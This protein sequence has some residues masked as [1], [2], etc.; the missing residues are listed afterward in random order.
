MNR[1]NIATLL[2]SGSFLASCAHPNDPIHESFG[3][4]TKA[5]MAAQII[6]PAPAG[7]GPVTADG[8]KVSAATERY[9]TD[10]V[11]QPEAEETSDA[12]NSGR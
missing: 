2:I 10:T 7:T 9:K 11:K 1:F 8:A 3:A 12:G 6:N 5:N 4:A